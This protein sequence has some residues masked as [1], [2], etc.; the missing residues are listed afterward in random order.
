MITYFIEII[1][2]VAYNSAAAGL[3]DPVISRNMNSAESV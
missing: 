1:A 3:F 2:S